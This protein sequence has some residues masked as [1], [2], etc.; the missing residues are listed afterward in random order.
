MPEAYVTK[1]CAHCGKEFEARVAAVKRGWG[2][3]CSKSCAAHLREKAKPGYNP[4]K[5][6]LNNNMR[7]NWNR[8]FQTEDPGDSEYWDHKD[9]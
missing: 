8:P 9:F 1:N 4:E 2:T 7:T 3:A 5:V 6:A